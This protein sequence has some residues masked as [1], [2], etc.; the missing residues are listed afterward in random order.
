MPIVNRV[1]EV[2][3][4]IAGWRRRLHRTSLAETLLGT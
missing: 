3:D 4:E 2:R 1:S